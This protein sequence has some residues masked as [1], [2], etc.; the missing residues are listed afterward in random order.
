MRCV[1][2]SSFS[3]GKST[4]ARLLAV[5][6]GLTVYQYDYHDA[7]RHNDRRIARLAALAGPAPAPAVAREWARA[8]R[9][10]ALPGAP[11]GTVRHE[12]RLAYPRPRVITPRDRIQAPG[13]PRRQRPDG[14]AEEAEARKAAVPK[15]EAIIDDEAEAEDVEG[16]DFIED[17]SELGEDDDDVAEEIVGADEEDSEEP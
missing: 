8:A 15:P 11:P 14:K 4:V 9:P 17:A 16:K 2:S 6:Y 10:A 13:Q 1:A 12:R 5:Q 3:A 7:R